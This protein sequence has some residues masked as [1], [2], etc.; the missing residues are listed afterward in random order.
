MRFVFSDIFG[1]SNIT[2]TLTTFKKTPSC[3]SK[4]YWTMCRAFDGKIFKLISIRRVPITLNFLSH[5]K[6]IAA[7]GNLCIVPL[8]E[9]CLLVDTREN[10]LEIK[11]GCVIGCILKMTT[12]V[13]THKLPDDCLRKKSEENFHFFLDLCEKF[14]YN[15]IKDSSNN[16]A[17][18]SS[19]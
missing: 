9:L 11:I 14:G 10:V 1:L 5:N 19:Q 3:T 15:L 12:F 13:F 4:P 8:L 16:T 18:K 7:I 6:F 17:A 2:K